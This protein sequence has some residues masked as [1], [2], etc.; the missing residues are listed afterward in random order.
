MFSNG[1]TG[2]MTVDAK[3]QVEET[4]E[5]GATQLETDGILWIGL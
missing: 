2:T 3:E 5:Q 4:S 1:R